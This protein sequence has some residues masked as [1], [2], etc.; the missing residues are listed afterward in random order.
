VLACISVCIAW[1]QNTPAAQASL[2]SC[3]ELTKLQ[4]RIHMLCLLYIYIYIYMRRPASSLIH[5][6]MC[7]PRIR[8]LV[9]KPS[10]RHPSQPHKFLLW[11][12]IMVECNMRGFKTL[13]LFILVLRRLTLVGTSCNVRG[14]QCGPS[15][16][17][18]VTPPPAS[19][20]QGFCPWMSSKVLKSP[21]IYI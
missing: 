18:Q 19:G 11:T 15:N 7:M 16:S 3:L 12:L 2:C 13:D 1:T 17:Q 10:A 9:L 5:I 21:Y 6:S 14:V 20:V 4:S 8:T